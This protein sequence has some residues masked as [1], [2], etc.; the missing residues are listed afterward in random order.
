MR[1]RSICALQV[2]LALARGLE[3]LVGDPLAPCVEVGC[4]DLAREPLGVAVADAAAEPALDVVVDDL[5]QA[6]ELALDRLGL[7]H[8]TSSTRSSA[9][10]GSTK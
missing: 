7:L 2:V 9:R 5:R 6:A 3:L 1:Q 10:W 8:S 4:L